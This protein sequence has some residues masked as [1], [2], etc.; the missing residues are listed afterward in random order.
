M[1]SALNVAVIL[2]TMS[3]SALGLQMLSS[4]LLAFIDDN[5]SVVVAVILSIMSLSLLKTL[6][7][8][9]PFHVVPLVGV[10]RNV[11]VTPGGIFQ[12]INTSFWYKDLFPE[13]FVV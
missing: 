3:L 6:L 7:L 13:I 8:L 12:S 2:T 5:V 4:V 11:I 1:Y 9:S 10:F